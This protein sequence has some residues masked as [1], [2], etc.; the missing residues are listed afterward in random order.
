M[1]S[2]GVAA[3]I[4]SKAG[5]NARPFFPSSI[6]LL[7]LCFSDSKLFRTQTQAFSLAVNFAALTPTPTQPSHEKSY[8]ALATLAD[9]MNQLHHSPYRSLRTSTGH[10]EG[11]RRDGERDERRQP[12]L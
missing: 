6:L 5:A 1:R 9:V 3:L 4:I 11:L 8:T 7:Y 12:R 2:K 10:V